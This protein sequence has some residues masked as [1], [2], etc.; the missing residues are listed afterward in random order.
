MKIYL[1]LVILTL[2]NLVSAQ[3][4]AWVFFK[5]KPDAPSFF[6]A[7]HLMLT[8]KA[9][10][11]RTKQ[12]ISVNEQDVPLCPDYVV[13]ISSSQGITIK[14]RSKWLNALHVI[15]SQ[16]NI[17]NLTSLSFVDHIE[18]A[19][20]SIHNS[21]PTISK[22]AKKISKTHQL[23]STI[24][25]NYGDAANQTTMIGVDAFHREGFNGEG[26]EIAVMDAGF[27]GVNSAESFNHLVDGDKV[28]GEVL[29]GYDYVS[30]SSDFYTN[31][32]STHGTQV[33]STM[34]AIK[35]NEFVGTSPKASFYLFITE[36]V[37]NE[38]PLEESL[39]VQAAEKADSLGVDIINTSLGY[40]Q[41]DDSKY[42]Y[43]YADMDG[44]TTFITRG[45]HIAAQKG[46]VVVN[47]AGNSGNS[48]WKYITAPADAKDIIT[49]GAVNANETITSFSSFGPSNDDRIKPETLAQGGSVYVVDENNVVRTSN[50]TSFSGPIIAGVSAC[51]WQAY[52]NKT[53]LEIRNMI[54]ENSEDYLSPTSQGGYGILR[55]QPLLANLSNDNINSESRKVEFVQYVNRIEFVLPQNLTS[56]IEVQIFSSLGNLIAEAS[57]SSANKSIN[58]SQLAKGIYFIKYAYAGKN[59]VKHLYKGIDAE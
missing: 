46:M 29:G 36:D 38:S 25:Y 9:L 7:P 16:S 45:A 21:V 42:D 59:Q 34:A 4:H 56:N 49:V 30:Q 51:L 5:D 31:T 2:T 44:K 22:S 55:V 32:G 26:V 33:L 47:S 50:G 13:Q 57:I 20:K 12:G 37:N 1:T 54:I 24:V 35:Q 10:E 3:E 43:T 27:F 8:Q 17:N 18:F 15:G 39:W 28:N 53:S 11:R 52:P 58:I 19:N 14:A 23:K 6:S 40:N 41:F 48:A